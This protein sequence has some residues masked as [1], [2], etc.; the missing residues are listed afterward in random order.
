VSEEKSTGIG[1]EQPSP[2]RHGYDWDVISTEL[3][4]NPG[5]W[6]KI[7]T[8]GPTSVVNGIRNGNVRQL[9]PEDGFESTT[10][11]NKRATEDSV[12]TCDLFLRYVPKR[13]KKR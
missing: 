11:N 1:W 5:Q 13:G 8:D 12:K 4:R 9:R 10:R 2:S 6:M 7:F 3:R